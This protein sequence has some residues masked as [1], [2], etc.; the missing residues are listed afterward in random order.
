MSLHKFLSCVVL[1]TLTFT[2][3]AAAISEPRPAPAGVQEGIVLDVQ[4]GNYVITYEAEDELRPKGFYQTIFIPATKIDPILKSRFHHRYS[5]KTI[6]YIYKIKNG[7]NAVQNIDNIDFIVGSMN[8]EMENPK[9]WKSI[10]IANFDGPGFRV[11]WHYSGG[12]DLGGITPR[13]KLG[14]FEIKSEDLPGISLMR[15]QGATPILG[16][17]GD[18]L[19]EE[20][21][22]ELKN[23]GKIEVDSIPRPAAVPLIPVPNPFDAATVLTSL[24]KHV[25]Q[26]MVG[27]KLGEFAPTR[28]FPGHAADKKAK[29]K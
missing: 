22:E 12:D 8:D 5:D 4:T 18:G 3:Q 15:F 16:F 25:N 13:A 6:A 7:S 17:A 26:D 14:G 29:R 1:Y 28:F 9:N 19:N 10:M 27:M 2:V 11:G 24:Q 23:L 21:E 20:M